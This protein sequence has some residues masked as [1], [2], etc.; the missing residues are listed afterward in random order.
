MKTNKPKGTKRSDLEFMKNPDQWPNRPIL[1]L[2][3]PLV[4]ENGLSRVAVL[5]AGA[6]WFNV[7]YGEN[8]WQ[9]A[10]RM[11]ANLVTWVEVTPEALVAGGWIVD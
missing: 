5:M 6:G 3:N 2:T 11:K 10:P 7:A 8:M 1:P 4:R 9:L